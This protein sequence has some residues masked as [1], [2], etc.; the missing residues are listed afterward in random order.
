MRPSSPATIVERRHLTQFRQ[1]LTQKVLALGRRFEPLC[2]LMSLLPGVAFSLLLFPAQTGRSLPVLF[3]F[4][5]DR[6]QPLRDAADSWP[7]Q[8][9]FLML[10]GLLT[11]DRN[12]RCRGSSCQSMDSNRISIPALR[13]PLANISQKEPGSAVCGFDDTFPLRSRFCDS[14]RIC[15]NSRVCA[16]QKPVAKCTHEIRLHVVATTQRPTLLR[17]LRKL[18]HGEHRA[19]ACGAHSRRSSCY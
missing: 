11:S 17:C 13:M 10:N 3:H 12:R 8:L 14:Y 7:L 9:H 1:V 18:S 2:C 15:V 6:I 4:G 5:L 16:S 19:H